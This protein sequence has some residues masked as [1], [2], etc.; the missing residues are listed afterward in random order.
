MSNIKFFYTLSTP[1][2]QPLYKR[3]YGLMATFVGL[4]SDI[5]ANVNLLRCN[6]IHILYYKLPTIEELFDC[7]SNN[8]DLVYIVDCEESE[9]NIAFTIT[10]NN[11]EP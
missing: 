9:Y 3:F 4:S 5:M 11:I 8:E 7:W 2:T 6:G 1:T 10:A